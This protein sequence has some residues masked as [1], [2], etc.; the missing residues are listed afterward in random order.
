[1]SNV[2]AFKN[3]KRGGP[4][5]VNGQVPPPRRVANLERRKP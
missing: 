3:P 4:R 2:L 5:V 1:M